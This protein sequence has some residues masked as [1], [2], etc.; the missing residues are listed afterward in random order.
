MGTD[1]PLWSPLP[2]WLKSVL[3]ALS[4]TGLA[5]IVSVSSA[6]NLPGTIASLVGV[7][8]GMALFLFI[9]KLQ[10]DL[11]NNRF[12]DA[13]RILERAEEIAGFGSYTLH[14]DAVGN[15]VVAWS[16]QLHRVLRPDVST[17]P[18]SLEKYVEHYVHP[19]DRPRVRRCM[20]H[21]LKLHD[22]ISLEYRI[23]QDKGP[24][25]HV[26]DHLEYVRSVDGIDIFHGQLHDITERRLA[27]QERLEAA[28]RFQSFVEQLGG[29]PYIAS[30]DAQATN[31][32]VSTKIIELLGFTPDQ[33]CGDPGL[34]FRQMH[35]EDRTGFLE[36]I[37]ATISSGTPLSMDYRLRRADGTIRWFH[38]EARLATDTA[39]RPL[40]LHGI[41]LDITERKLAQEE[42]TRSQV[43]LKRLIGALDDIREDEQKRLAREMHDDLGQLLAAMK[44]DLS[45]LAQQIP[46][47]DGSVLQ[48]LDAINELVNSMLISVRL[49]IADLPPKLLEEVG[50]FDA[51]RM[52]ARNFEGRYGV[53]CHLRLPDKP[54][55][56]PGKATSMLYRLVQESLTNIAKH[57]QATRVDIAMEAEPS[58]LVLSVVDN[59]IGASLADLHKAGSFGLVCMRERIA[60]FDGELNIQT[61]P[62][63]GLAV[64]VT[65]PL[66]VFE[67]TAIVEADQTAAPET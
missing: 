50:L 27:E 6:T 28:S 34:K 33:W 1:S 29:M 39:G 19:D 43:E 25:R 37:A 21:A 40:F 9:R 60:A 58:F 8:A 16:P 23:V 7:A 48:R 47:S 49:I 46:A 15:A 20:E 51:L 24:I 4:G 2:A 41:A 26:L 18:A 14:N 67:N 22:T 10:H 66:A 55:S 57:A 3:P 65:L 62:G 12:N 31:I 17:L 35:N 30:I 64:R 36:S 44:M 56:F 61:A 54:S 11:G 42:L 38:D 53:S 32:Y 13:R 52:L 45:V 59:G 63:A 5:S